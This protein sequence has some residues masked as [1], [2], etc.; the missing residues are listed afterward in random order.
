MHI[1]TVL[2]HHSCL[3]TTIDTLWK[4]NLIILVIGRV[5]SQQTWQVVCRL[6]LFSTIILSCWPSVPLLLL[7][8]YLNC[9]NSSSLVNITAELFEGFQEQMFGPNLTQNNH[10][11]PNYPINCRNNR[12]STILQTKQEILYLL[13]ENYLF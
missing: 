10:F 2:S 4:Y 13:L 8:A 12:I 11:A 3:Q 6:F 7:M 1:K 5:I 9:Y